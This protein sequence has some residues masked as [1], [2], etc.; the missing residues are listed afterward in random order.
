MIDIIM[1]HYVR[2]N[3]NYNFDCFSRRRCEFEAQ[4][5]FFLDK[6]DILDP[7]DLDKIFFYLN[8]NDRAF[9]L[10]FDDGYKDHLYCAN[11]L[12]SLN[13]NAIFFPP[14]KVLKSDLLDVNAIHFL[15]GLREIEH[16]LI[17]DYI[18]NYLKKNNLKIL[19]GNKFIEINEYLKID[20]GSRYDNQTV[21][22]IK[23]LLQRD[24]V[25]SNQRKVLINSVLE[26]FS[27]YKSMDIAKELYLSE[28]EIQEMYKLGMVFG[29]HSNNHYWLNTLTFEEQYREIKESYL[30]FE[31]L[32]ILDN[33]DPKILCYPF[34]AYNK[35][36]LKI[37]NL[38]GVSYAVTTN[39][40]SAY[41][42]K[43]NFNSKF[44]L[45]RWDTNDAWDNKLNIPKYPL[46]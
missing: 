42:T 8:N 36:T 19:I 28:M 33:N 30:E 18:I 35:D 2:D 9:L 40:G 7:R 23:R 45:N 5:N 14:I 21:I 37:N 1:Y 4:I 34:G 25:G 17:L 13:V 22:V 20:F 15:I 29:S 43:N 6:A 41:V 46:H 24:I 11:F 39:V 31:R 3:E 38:L 27:A 44:E 10:T 26:N 16:D 32:K 12:N